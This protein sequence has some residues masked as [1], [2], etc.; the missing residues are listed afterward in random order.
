MD[1]EIRVKTNAKRIHGLI[2][3]Q[4]SH[5]LRALLKQD[6]KYEENDRKQNVLWLLEQLKKIASGL[7]SKSNKRCNVFYALLAFVTMK[8]GSDESD[9]ACLKRFR[10]NLDTLCSAG[11]QHILCSPDLIEA[12]D[13]DDVT[14]AETG[15][16]RKQV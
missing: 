13:K 5:S 6:K 12:A 8:Q 14:E 2:K 15:N 10:V 9:S 7:D 16:R 3:G 1:R 4:C 11:G